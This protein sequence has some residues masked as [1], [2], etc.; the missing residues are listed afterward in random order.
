MANVARDLLWPKDKNIIARV[1]FLY[2]G[3]GDSTIVLVANGTTYKTVLI[4]INLDLDNGGIDV[5]HLMSNLLE[6]QDNCLNVFV[7]TH[8]HNDHLSGIME[9]CDAVDIGEVWH[10]GHKPG[11]KHYDAYQN[12][13][14]VIARVKESG[15]SETELSGSK[16]PKSFGEAEYYVLAPASYVIDDIEGESA[17]ERYRRIHEQCAVLKFGKGSKWVMITG[18]AD[19]D[20]WEK[21]ITNYHKE[22]LQSIVLGAPHHGSRS[23][24]RYQEEDEPYLDALHQI[25]PTYVVISAPISKE[26]PHNHP[27]DDAIS[28]YVEQVKDEENVLHTGARRHSFICDIYRDGELAIQEDNGALTEKYGLVSGAETDEKK[29]SVFIPPV[30]PPVDSRPMGSCWK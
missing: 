28:L 15:G 12:L 4:D 6:D 8:P 20:A 17:E 11:K 26:S 24:F 22:R 13:Q 10:S 23:F 3:Q 19:R 29:S 16:D 7:N 2:V 27:H 25:S 9:L 30:V 14:K 5:P 1:V 21:H 18:D